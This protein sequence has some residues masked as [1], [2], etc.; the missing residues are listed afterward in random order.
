[1]LRSHHLF[2]RLLIAVGIAVALAA[3][4]KTETAAEKGPAEKAGQKLDQAASRAGEELNKAA[5]A[6]GK[7]MQQLGQKIQDSAEQAQQGQQKKE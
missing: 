1:M 7:G 5:E 6:A 4:Q 2:S 3:C